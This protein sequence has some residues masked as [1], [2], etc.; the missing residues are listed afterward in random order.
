M[1]IK[2]SQKLFSLLSYIEFKDDVFEKSR[3]AVILYTQLSSYMKST[4]AVFQPNRLTI[5]ERL[6]GFFECVQCTVDPS[7]P[8]HKG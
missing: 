5:C 3:I 1:L 8:A 7:W 4:V 2:V 6:C